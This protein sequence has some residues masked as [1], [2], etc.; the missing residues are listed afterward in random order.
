MIL[1]LSGS[2]VEELHD[3]IGGVVADMSSEIAAT[4]NPTFRK[5]LR[6][7]RERLRGVLTQLDAVKG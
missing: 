6:D 1:E 7:R 2:L 4:D 5:R 3:T